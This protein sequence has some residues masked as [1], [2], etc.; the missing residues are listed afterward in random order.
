[1]V[2]VTDQLSLFFAVD[3]VCAGAVHNYYSASGS[4]FIRRYRTC[5]CAHFPLQPH[6]T[7]RPPEGNSEYFIQTGSRRQCL[8]NFA[9][10]IAVFLLHIPKTYPHGFQSHLT[11]AIR[12]NNEWKANAFVM[13]FLNV[14]CSALRLHLPG[15]FG[16]LVKHAPAVPPYAT[17][18]CVIPAVRSR[19]N[20]SILH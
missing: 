9:S 16:L 20:L 11:V 14:G 8:G 4:M 10:G 19:R 5:T 7:L 18:P 1:M 6:K 13:N 17:G 3:F 12:A 2:S 15:I